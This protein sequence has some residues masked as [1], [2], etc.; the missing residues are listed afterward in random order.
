MN[1]RDDYPILSGSLSE[2]HYG[3]AMDE[4]D[5]RRN[6]AGR[7]IRKIEE[8]AGERDAA[9]ADADR[10]AESIQDYRFSERNKAIAAH[11]DAVAKRGPR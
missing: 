2:L 10:L 1:A 5:S 8:V 9:E 4:I 3:K 11:A 7:L 6:Q